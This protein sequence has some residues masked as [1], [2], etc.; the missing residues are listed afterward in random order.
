MKG[1]YVETVATDGNYFKGSAHL[2]HLRPF[3][4][5]RSFVLIQG[6]ITKCSECMV[7]SR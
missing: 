3:R 4:I 1:L 2:L 7:M 5:M 6:K